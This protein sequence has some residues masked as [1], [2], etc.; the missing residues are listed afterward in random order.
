[1]VYTDLPDMD[2]IWQVNIC[3]LPNQLEQFGVTTLN[4]KAVSLK[5]HQTDIF[6]EQGVPLPTGSW[7]SARRVDVCIGDSTMYET[8]ADSGN[9]REVRCLTVLC[10]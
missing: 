3:M 2:S 4:G 7:Q 6:E 1:M 5:A 8:T 9:R 10:D